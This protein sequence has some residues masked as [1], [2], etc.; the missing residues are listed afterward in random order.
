M[1]LILFGSRQKIDLRP[2]LSLDYSAALFDNYDPG[3]RREM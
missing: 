2:F 3:D 1:Y